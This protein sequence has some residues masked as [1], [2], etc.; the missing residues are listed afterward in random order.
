MCRTHVLAQVN[1][2][3]TNFKVE[4]EDI[5]AKYDSIEFNEVTKSPKHI[6][7]LAEESLI[8]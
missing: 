5:E 1:T 4:T 6:L 7:K 8:E 3:I 2:F